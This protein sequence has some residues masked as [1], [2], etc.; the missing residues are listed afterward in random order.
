MSHT[1]SLGTQIPIVGCF[2][3]SEARCFY[4]LPSFHDQLN[5]FDSNWSHVDCCASGFVN[6]LKLT[7]HSSPPSQFA[8]TPCTRY[9]SNLI[10]METFERQTFPNLSTMLTSLFQV[11]H[12]SIGFL[13][14]KIIWTVLGVSPKEIDNC[15]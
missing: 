3:T 9:M 14:N 7:F 12:N 6:C 1:H 11:I 2:S 4:V 15:K 8:L 5:G 13:Y 10:T